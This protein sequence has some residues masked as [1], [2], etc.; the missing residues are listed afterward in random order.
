M[1]NRRRGLTQ[2]LHMIGTL[3]FE[4]TIFPQFKIFSLTLGRSKKKLQ[5]RHKTSFEVQL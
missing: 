1:G 4:Q 5:W 2:D 3:N